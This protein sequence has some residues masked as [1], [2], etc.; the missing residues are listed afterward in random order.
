M[1]GLPQIPEGCPW[2]Y[3]DERRSGI[4]GEEL[5]REISHN[6]PLFRICSRL[7]VLAACEANDDVLA[8]RTDVENELFCIHL[9]WAG[10]QNRLSEN[11]PAFQTI[12]RGDL[13]QFFAGYC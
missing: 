10:D 4:L 2:S 8:I 3:V 1:P 5:K 12:N 9:T 11:S 6:H 7:Q 13:A